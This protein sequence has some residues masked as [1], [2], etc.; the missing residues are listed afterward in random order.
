MEGKKKGAMLKEFA[1]ITRSDLENAPYQPA[2]MS[3]GIF[4]GQKRMGDIHSSNTDILG[5]I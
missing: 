1:R 2:E 5:N 4:P 3:S